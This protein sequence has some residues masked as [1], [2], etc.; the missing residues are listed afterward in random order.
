MGTDEPAH[1]GDL[2]GALAGEVD[3]QAIHQYRILLRDRS[4]GQLV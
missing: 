3:G 1:L 4:R 2:I